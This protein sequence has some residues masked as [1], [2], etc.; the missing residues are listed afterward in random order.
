MESSEVGATAVPLV[1]DALMSELFVGA[2]AGMY[3]VNAQGVVIACNPWAERLLG[4]AQGTLIGV[5][6]HHAMHPHP[7]DGLD[8]PAQRPVLEDVALGKRSSGDRAVLLRADGSALQVWWSAAPLPP[9]PDTA[10]ERWSSSRTP[11]RSVSVT[12]D[13]RTAT[14]TVR[15][16][17]SR[18][19]TTSRRTPGSAN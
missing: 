2:G 10:P 19:N 7:G 1:G 5:N 8:L 18:P 3:A 17:G 14:R 6:A 12:A 16:C 11:P 15:R 4:Y 13:E 9:G